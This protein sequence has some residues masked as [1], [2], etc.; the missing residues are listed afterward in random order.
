MFTAGIVLSDDICLLMLIRYSGPKLQMDF[1]SFVL[2][3][4][5]AEKTES[6][7]LGSR[8]G[9][10]SSAWIA[11]GGWGGGRGGAP[12]RPGSQA[13]FWLPAC[14]SRLHL[15]TLICTLPFPEAEV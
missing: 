7:L 9:G 6:E 5:R 4:L 10:A 13:G 3:M 11:G 12:C 14:Q 8:G 2:L 15:P 1:V